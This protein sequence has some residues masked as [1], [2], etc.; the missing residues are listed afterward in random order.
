MNWAN[1][2]SQ[3]VLDSFYWKLISYNFMT[4]FIDIFIVED[5]K[6][7]I[8]KAAYLN[9]NTSNNVE[10]PGDVQIVVTLTVRDMLIYLE[11]NPGHS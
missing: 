1:L 11:K 4:S 10:L 9:L 7:T 5:L 3:I 8:L 2:I 6:R